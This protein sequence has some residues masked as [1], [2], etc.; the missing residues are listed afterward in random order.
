MAEVADDI[1]NI[2]GVYLVKNKD[3]NRKFKFR[4]SSLFLNLVIEVFI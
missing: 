3:D 1:S 4:L 2:A